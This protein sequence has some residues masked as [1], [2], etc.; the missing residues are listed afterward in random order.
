MLI[1]LSVFVQV[2]PIVEDDSPLEERKKVN[3]LLTRT[4]AIVQPNSI[5]VTA[6]HVPEGSTSK[7]YSHSFRSYPQSAICVC[8]QCSSCMG[9]LGCVVF[10]TLY[11]MIQNFIAN[12]I[13]HIV[14]FW[15]DLSR[16]A[17]HEELGLVGIVEEW[18]QSRE[19]LS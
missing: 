17:W 6:T 16:D 11:R 3:T 2:P 19:D 5:F 1:F 10:V 12:R 18:E 8:F 4:F 9:C 14:L 15:I 7:T 13:R